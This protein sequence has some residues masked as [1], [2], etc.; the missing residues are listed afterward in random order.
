MNCSLFIFDRL[1]AKQMLQRS[2]AC[3]INMQ[4]RPKGVIRGQITN[5]KGIIIPI[6]TIHMPYVPSSVQD[7]HI[8]V[9]TSW[10][11]CL[12]NQASPTPDICITYYRKLLPKYLFPN[13]HLS[14]SR[15]LNIFSPF[16]PFQILSQQQQ[17]QSKRLRQFQTYST[18][19]AIT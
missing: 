12:S 14:V 9:K 2:V 13:T 6:V 18:N 15:I 1:Q 17:S 3:F 5:I 7:R 4:N 8:N 19:Q 11:P 10:T 16:P